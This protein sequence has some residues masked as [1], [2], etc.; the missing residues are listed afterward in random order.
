[1]LDD[2]LRECLTFDDVLLIPAYSEVLPKDVEVR[3]R[4]CRGFELNIPILSAAMDSV[5]EA[6]TAITMAREGGIGI[7][8]FEREG[9]FLQPYLERNVEC[10][11]ELRVLRRM[12]MQIDETRQKIRAVRQG[13]KHARRRLLLLILRV[14]LIIGAMDGNNGAIIADRNQGILEEI[15]LAESGGMKAR[16]NECLAAQMIHKKSHAPPE[17]LSPALWH[18]LGLAVPSDRWHDPMMIQLY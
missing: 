1:M 14:V 4:L 6:R 17:L 10:A 18:R 12:D 7:S 9:V 5:T 16:C 3:T 2:K 13:H 8:R 15:D 11:A